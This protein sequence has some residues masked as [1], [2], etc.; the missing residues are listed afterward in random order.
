MQNRAKRYTYRIEWSPEDGT[1]V[2]RCAEFPSLGAHGPS[3]EEALREIIS[4]VE[5]AVE[6]MSEKGEAIPEPLTTKS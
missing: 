3:P 1:F 2:G 6:D 5:H 4:A